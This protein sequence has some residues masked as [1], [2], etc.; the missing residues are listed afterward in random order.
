MSFDNVDRFALLDDAWWL[1]FWRLGMGAS[2]NN[3]ADKFYDD[4][5]PLLLKKPLDAALVDTGCYVDDSACPLRT[6]ERAVLT[7]YVIGCVGR[8]LCMYPI[9]QWHWTEVDTPLSC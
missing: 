1:M 3:T 8:R 2:K 5:L 7:G 4:L 9:A 6:N